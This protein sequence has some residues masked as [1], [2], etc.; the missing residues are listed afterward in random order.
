VVNTEE[1]VNEK[2]EEQV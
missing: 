1:T 2:A